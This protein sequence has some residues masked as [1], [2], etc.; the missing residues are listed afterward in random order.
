MKNEESEIKQLILTVLEDWSELQPN[1]ESPA[2][3]EMLA[4]KLSLPLEDYMSTLVEEVL[5]MYD[6]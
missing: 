2:T 5:G 4:T 1:M 3:R 6:E